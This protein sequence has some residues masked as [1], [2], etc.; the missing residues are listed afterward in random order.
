[1]EKLD[2]K[3]PKKEYVFTELLVGLTVLGSG[4]VRRINHSIRQPLI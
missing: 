1:M 2:S 4:G 3:L